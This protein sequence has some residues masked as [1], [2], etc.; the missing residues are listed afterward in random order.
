MA[1]KS[2]LREFTEEI[3]N[4]NKESASL[5]VMLQDLAKAMKENAK[6]ASEFT[7]DSVE[8]FT[9]GTKEAINLAKA[10]QGITLQNLKN[11]KSQEAFETK[12]EKAQS[13]IAKVS[14]KIA[15]LEE[16]RLNASKSE[17]AFID[18][19][20]KTLVDTEETL[21]ESVKQG[22]K[23]TQSFQ[24]IKDLD[25][26]SGVSDLVQ[27]I[28]VL[29]KIFPEFSKASKVFRDNI[30]DGKSA[31]TALGKSSLETIGALG[32]LSLGLVVGKVVEEVTNIDKK[33][34]DF[35]RSLGISSKE[36]FVLNDNMMRASLAS[37]KLYFNSDR[38]AEA[39]LSVNQ[40]LGTNVTISS[41]MAENFSALVYRLGL[42]N[43][44]A[45]RFNLTS[46]A[47]GKNAKEYTGQITAQ[48]KL[49]NGEKKLQIDNRQIIKDISNTSARTQ[50]S[51]KAQNKSLV[52]AAYNAKS[53]GLNLSQVEKISD[54]LL[55]FEQSISAELEAELLTGRS[56]NLEQARLYAL[57]NDMEGVTK[58]IAK[59]GITSYNFGRM[60]RIEQEAIAGALGMGA[61]EL[62]DSLK[63]QDQIKTLSKESGYRDAKSLDDLKQ[64]IA[65]KAKDIGYEKALA[66]VGNEELKNQLDAATVNEQMLEQQKKAAESMA[67]AFGP[68]GLQKS[69]DLIKESIDKLI[70]AIEILAG[71]QLAKG[72]FDVAKGAKDIFGFFKGTKDVVGGTN[73]GLK[74]MAQQ[75][76]A[77][78]ATNPGMT[79]K[80]ALSAIRAGGGGAGKAAGKGILKGLGKSF[81]KKIPIIGAIAGLGFAASRALEGDWAGAGLEAASGLAGTIPGVGTAASVGIDA[82]LA[83]RD[84][85]GPEFANGGIITKKITNATI[86]EAGREA[87][88]PLDSPRGK[89]ILGGGSAEL[90]EIKNI[91][92][93]I[94]AKN[95]DVYMDSTKVGTGLNLGTV[96]IQ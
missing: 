30:V 28:P 42:S 92:S 29:N 51:L 86:G 78:K 65:L 48:V 15:L 79:S 9:E 39:M 35:S 54:S 93:Q 69:L 80:A 62:A 96:R 32:K 61:E 14:A 1:K 27:Q 70:L 47:L 85:S 44:E 31:M 87:V 76:A 66:S 17:K 5:V 53:L 82:A 75:V 88:V 57:N 95:T 68:N 6:A 94:L 16:R 60:N 18:S 83:A 84:M 22:Q 55:N 7:G 21:K 77:M 10:L 11:K 40:T 37:E 36:A 46:V 73:S 34:V 81:L 43:E 50:I 8:S 56:I 4:F 71:I 49:L 59:Q 3:K 52:D 19:A 45:T 90:A 26:F 89:E 33:T 2:D 74:T 12:I 64:R 58:E 67:V 24:T 72:V 13:N 38:F 20:L 23:L 25:P 63:F 41:D 91:L